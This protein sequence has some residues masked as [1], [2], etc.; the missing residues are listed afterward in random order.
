MEQARNSRL[1]QPADDQLALAESFAELANLEPV[2]GL[3]EPEQLKVASRFLYAL[4]ERL[5]T[6]FHRV[7]R[8]RGS[9][10]H[11]AVASYLMVIQHHVRGVLRDLFAGQPATSPRLR[12]EP[13]TWRLEDGSLTVER[14]PHEPVVAAFVE[15][16][17]RPGPFPFRICPVCQRIFARVRRQRFCSPPC[18]S[19]AVEASRKEE[20]R[21]YMRRLMAA[22]RAKM[23]K[24]RR[25][26]GR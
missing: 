15:L 6:G 19:R 26:K 9:G 25:T 10:S 16:C 17:E 22:R 20:R 2:E 24:T 1:T 11:E 7:A 23:R 4:P 12:A 8:Q 3:A 18:A 21:E 14:H 13:A 5:R